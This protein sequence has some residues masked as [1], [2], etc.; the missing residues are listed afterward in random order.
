MR[1][2]PP[3]PT[4]SPINFKCSWCDDKIEKRPFFQLESYH[5]EVDKRI[6]CSLGFIIQF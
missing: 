2:P 6:I 1:Y 5:H 3:H 4:P